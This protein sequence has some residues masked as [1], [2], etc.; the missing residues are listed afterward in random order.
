MFDHVIQYGMNSFSFGADLYDEV[1]AEGGYVYHIH[2]IDRD[3]VEATFEKIYENLKDIGEK[4]FMNPNGFL[5][6]I[7]CLI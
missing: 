6:I 2:E 3:G 1:L 5:L 7:L 4:D